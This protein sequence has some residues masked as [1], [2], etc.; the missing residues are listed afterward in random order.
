[1]YQYGRN[2]LLTIY[3]RDVGN[4]FTLQSSPTNEGL[5]VTFDIQK[6][7]DNKSTANTA[8]VVIYNLSQAT[9]SKLSDKQMACQITLSVG[10]G[11]ELVQILVGDVLQISSKQEGTEIQTTFSIA[12]G[13]VTLNAAKISKTYPEGTTVKQVLEDAATVLDCPKV[14]ITGD[15]ANKALT[16]GYP[17]F[18][19]LKQVLDDVCYANNMEWDIAGGELTV[20]DKRSVLASST[21]EDA[22]VLSS[23]TGMIGVPLTRHETV[24]V[25]ADQPIQDNEEAI[26]PETKTLKSGK[27]VVAKKRKQ[28][29]F[30]IEVKALLNPNCKTNGLIKV[31]SDKTELSG[32]YRVRNIKY[33]GDTR[34]NDWIMTIFGD[35]TRD[36]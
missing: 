24:T 21:K 33:V 3:D 19:T 2:Y 1:M 35:D 16:Y 27:V 23:E 17:A 6:N 4:L 7:V 11:T 31:V 22:I 5:R 8:K 20:K 30:N 18:G 32:Y 15:N 12:E 25:S 26:S 36:L 13:F 10:Y 14:A 28:V 29:R 34:G 9:L